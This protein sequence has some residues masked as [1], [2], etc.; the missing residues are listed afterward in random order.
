MQG[1][2]LCL[3]QL[4]VVFSHSHYAIF[5]EDAA[6]QVNTTQEITALLLLQ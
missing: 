4:L 6:D 1:L 3:S 2:V 5:M